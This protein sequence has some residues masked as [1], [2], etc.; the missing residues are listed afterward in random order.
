MKTILPLLSASLLTLVAVCTP[1]RA[2]PGM[3]TEEANAKL[4]QALHDGTMVTGFQGLSPRQL[5]PDLYPPAPA[6]AG[7]TDEQAAADLAR[8]LC[9]GTM[10]TGYQ[11]LSERQLHPDLYPARAVAPGKT[12]EQVQN[13]LAASMRNGNVTTGFQGLTPRQLSYGNF[14]PNDGLATANRDFAQHQAATRTS[15]K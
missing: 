14:Q 1:A 4:A 6:V 7:K 13:E 11:G 2:G 10:V 12:R 9:D 3:T 15:G 5:H 8:A